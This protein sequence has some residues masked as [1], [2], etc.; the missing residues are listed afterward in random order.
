MRKRMIIK[1]LLDPAHRSTEELA[2]KL[3]LPFLLLLKSLDLLAI[4][5]HLAINCSLKCTQHKV[6]QWWRLHDVAVETC[7]CT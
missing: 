1:E 5:E 3:Q 2:G 6:E 7:A 4:S